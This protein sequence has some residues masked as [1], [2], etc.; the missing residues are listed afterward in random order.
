M[1]SALL[2]EG[3]DQARL[4][5]RASWPGA[6]A[7]LESG[8]DARDD[9]S[10]MPSANLALRRGLAD[11]W[12]TRA[13]CVC[14]VLSTGRCRTQSRSHASCDRAGGDPHT[15]TSL[16]TCGLR[17]SVAMWRSRSLPREPASCSSAR[18]F[19]RPASRFRA[20]DGRAAWV[21]RIA[22]APGGSGRGALRSLSV[23][24]PLLWDA[25]IEKHIGA[26]AALGVP[27]P[28]GGNVL[29]RPGGR[30]PRST[31]E[32][33]DRRHNRRP[34]QEMLEAQCDYRCR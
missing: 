25:L 23:T 4:G 2:S 11:A 26:R 5:D 16:T 18:T 30:R 8:L 14:Q 24:F 34:K 10:S 1:R 7:R 33:N 9:S 19:S 12:E 27:T 21:T 15:S 28:C 20:C 32:R 17:L 3:I 31:P 29:W 6:D 22:P 13:R